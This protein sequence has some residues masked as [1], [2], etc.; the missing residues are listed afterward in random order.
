MSFRIETEQVS[1]YEVPSLNVLRAWLKDD[2]VR[3]DWIVENTDTKERRTITEWLGLETGDAASDQLLEGG[4]SKSASSATSLYVLHPNGERRGPITMADL[5]SDI[6]N[7][8]VKKEWLV[9]DMAA[10]DP[11]PA[12][13]VLQRAEAKAIKEETGT[14]PE[15]AL[16]LHSYLYVLDDFGRRM[17][18]LT[19]TQ[20][21]MWVYTGRAKDDSEVYSLADC[22]Q[23][24][25]LEALQKSG[26]G[27][28]SF[29]VRRAK[30]KWKKTTEGRWAVYLGL[31][32][33]LMLG[34]PF[35]SLASAGFAG[36]FSLRALDR[37]DLKG[38]IGIGS[39][40]LAIAIALSV[41]LN[42]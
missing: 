39:A 20:L 23:M 24:T 7:G 9:L 27:P 42:R 3:G 37:R 14:S 12:L 35:I 16:S 2:R 34:V 40:A 21:A 18:P 41:L 19:P 32:S 25:A 31:L 8:R 36:Y 1:T 30:R 13:L 5:K 15:D 11:L 29:A 38:Y 17:G 6:K 22:D 26:M 4:K 28:A 10:G 33:L